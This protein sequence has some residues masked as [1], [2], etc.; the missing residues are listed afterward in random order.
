MRTFTIILLIIFT[1]ITFAH[2]GKIKDKY[3]RV[4]GYADQDDDSVIIKDVYGR[5]MY[6][7]EDYEITDEYGD[8]V[9]EFSN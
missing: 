2:D 8:K 1:S 6:E 7:I 3:G 5:K 9:M 4:I